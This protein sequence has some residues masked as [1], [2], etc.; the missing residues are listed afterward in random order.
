MNIE[1]LNKDIYQIVNKNNTAT[2]QGS[3]SNCLNY[4][5]YRFLIKFYTAP[6]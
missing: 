3:H 1:K 4:M 5:A 6:E 2:S